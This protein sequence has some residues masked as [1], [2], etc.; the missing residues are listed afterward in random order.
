MILN[1]SNPELHV[2]LKEISEIFF[3]F[4]SF[5]V[6]KIPQNF[7]C[8]ELNSTKG[9]FPEIFYLIDDTMKLG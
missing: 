8:F 1:K 7:P 6:L 4:R 9:K 2:W 5:E 3:C